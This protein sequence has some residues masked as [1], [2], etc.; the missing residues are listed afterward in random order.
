MQWLAKISVKRPVFATVLILFIT[1]IGVVGYFQLG[2]D[3]FPKVDFPTVVRRV[4]PRGAADGFEITMRRRGRVTISG[5]DELRRLERSRKVPAFTLTKTS[6]LRRKRSRD[7]VG[8]VTL[9]RHDAP[10]V[11][12]MDPD[13]AD[14]HVS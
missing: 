2:I 14:P 5:I 12:K 10:V 4:S 1:V 9:L 3:R 13:D 6:T 8:R 7:H 11:S